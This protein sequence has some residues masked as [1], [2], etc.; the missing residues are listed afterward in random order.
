MDR[1][2]IGDET[3]AS[4]TSAFG[5]PGESDNG[6]RVVEFCDESTQGWQGFKMEW[7]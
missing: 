1:L 3:K 4:I 6:R 2:Q 7:R 5:V